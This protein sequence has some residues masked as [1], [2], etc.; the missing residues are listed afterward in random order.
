MCGLL[1]FLERIA[2]ILLQ[3]RLFGCAG[4]DKFTSMRPIFRARIL[5][6]APDRLSKKKAGVQNQ[7]QSACLIK[8]QLETFIFVLCYLN[9]IYS[10]PFYCKSIKGIC[11]EAPAVC[12][13]FECLNKMHL[14][15]SFSYFRRI[16]LK[17]FRR[18]CWKHGILLHIKSATDALTKICRKTSEQCSWERHHRCFW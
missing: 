9:R 2:Y 1:T 11:N 7:S 3:D 4:L 5:T 8:K 18:V 15:E 16:R 14:K 17:M 6:C 12:M 10:F 13:L